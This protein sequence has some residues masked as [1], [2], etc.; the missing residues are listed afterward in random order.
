MVELLLTDIILRLVIAAVLGALVGLERE[1]HRLPAGLKTHALVCLGAAL[2]TLAS[3]QFSILDDRVTLGLLATGVVSGIGFLGAGVIFSDKK[4]VH[5]ITTAATIWTV[6]ALGL[7]IGI[8]HYV[9]AII[10]ALIIYAVLILGTFFEKNFLHEKRL[11][12]V[13]N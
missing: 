4:G 9:M 10:A 2:F 8:G 3:I 1:V 12:R 6:A 7:V 5:G 13:G 11:E